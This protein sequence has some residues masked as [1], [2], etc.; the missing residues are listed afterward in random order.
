M[1]GLVKHMRL[2]GSHQGILLSK[3]CFFDLLLGQGVEQKSTIA[4][5]NFRYL[6][7]IAAFLI[8][9]MALHFVEQALLLRL[10]ELTQREASAGFS[11]YLFFGLRWLMALLFAAVFLHELHLI[12]KAK[13]ANHFV[14]EMHM[15]RFFHDVRAPL[16]TLKTILKSQG[17]K[18]E[19]G[20]SALERIETMLAKLKDSSLHIKESG[21]TANKGQVVSSLD[22]SLERMIQEKEFLFG[23][24]IQFSL[25]VL[26]TIPNVQADPGVLPRI[27]CNLFN[28]ACEAI[29]VKKD[30]LVSVDT[31]HSA[32]HPYSGKIATDLWCERDRVYLKIKD[33]G[34][35]IPHHVLKSLGNKKISYGKNLQLGGNLKKQPFAHQGI[36]VFSASQELKSWGGEIYFTSEEG[37]GTSVLVGLRVVS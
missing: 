35:G 37:L 34:A 25:N 30:S 16:C 13:S 9:L 28:N 23:D 7:W 8:S 31:A 21:V 26:N 20:E 4:K 19:I 2:L 11:D 32:A 33:N 12:L 36:G 5:P 14:Q 22:Q 18:S 1:L 17:L 27:L 3:I 24:Q 10:Q 29:L 6:L 15:D